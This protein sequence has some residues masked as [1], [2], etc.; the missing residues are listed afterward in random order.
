[1]TEFNCSAGGQYSAGNCVE[2]WLED[3][4]VNVLYLDNAEVTVETKKEMFEVY[5]DITKGKKHPFL[6][7]AAGSI[8][9]TKEARD[10]ASEMESLQPFLAV[11][12]FAPTLGYRLMAEFY[13]KF[14]KPAIPYKVFKEKEDAIRWLK[15]F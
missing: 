5:K 2:I 7:S 15:T 11:A 9:F 10:F 3:G 13:A 1:M 4:I 6:F 14:N 12:M 8:W